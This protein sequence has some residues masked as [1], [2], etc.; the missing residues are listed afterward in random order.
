MNIPDSML[1]WLSHRRGRDWLVAGMLAAVAGSTSAS[2]YKFTD[3][4]TLG[5][6]TSTGTAINA[7]GRVVGYSE[8]PD[9]SP[10]AAVWKGRRA[11]PLGRRFA[12]R[13]SYAYALNDANDAA[14]M[15]W[16]DEVVSYR[17]TLWRDGQ[18]IDLGS[19]GV[20][21]ARPADSMPVA[22]S[23]A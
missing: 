10:Y 17:A 2:P 19:L 5:G 22:T 14:G 4:G 15:R 6:R 16:V 20:T 18:V 21:A 13:G 23:S 11:L 9:Y 8:Q 1:C 3:L 7:T 12:Q